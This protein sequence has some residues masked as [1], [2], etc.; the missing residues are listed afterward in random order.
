[1]TAMR[2][3][4]PLAQN[5]TRYASSVTAQSEN[6]PCSIRSSLVQAWASA[7][8]RA[9][10]SAAAEDEAAANSRLSVR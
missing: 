2:N 5:S 4:E 3:A 6:P 9:R 10:W 7:T 8:A 1:M